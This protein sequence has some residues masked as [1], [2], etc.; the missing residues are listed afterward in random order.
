VVDEV[1]LTLNVVVGAA[2]ADFF[3]VLA[4]V[5]RTS[6]V[7]ALPL[8]AAALGGVAPA[9]EKPLTV[10]DEPVTA[11]TLPLAKLTELA[12]VPGN[13]PGRADPPGAA[14]PE[15]A[16]PDPDGGAVELDEPELVPVWADGEPPGKP[17]RHPRR[18][19]R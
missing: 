16:A 6:D 8:E 19:R 18:R 15:G 9:D 5:V 10:I 2:A 3:F 12:P 1:T 7:V 11:V 17:L 13:P 14:P 4:A